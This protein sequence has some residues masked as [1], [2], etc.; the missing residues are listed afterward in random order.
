MAFDNTCK[1]LAEHFSADIASWSLGTPIALN[2]LEPSELFTE[3]I[4]AD[5]VILLETQDLLAHIEF[6]T[7]PDVTVYFKSATRIRFL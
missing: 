1:F 3:P 6:Q 5:A 7:D 4:R 2:R